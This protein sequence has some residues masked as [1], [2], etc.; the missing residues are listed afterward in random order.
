MSTLH[1]HT[2]GEVGK[3]CQNVFFLANIVLQLDI[4]VRNV[5]AIGLIGFSVFSSAEVCVHNVLSIVVSAP[6]RVMVRVHEPMCLPSV[7]LKQRKASVHCC[8]DPGARV[9]IN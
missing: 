6:C 3:Y 5:A 1:L 9:L 7:K 2:G 4:L 8:Q